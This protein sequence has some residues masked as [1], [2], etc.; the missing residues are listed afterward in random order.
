MA[1]K[2]APKGSTAAGSGKP[3][4]KKPFPGAAPP[5]TARGAVRK[6]RKAAQKKGK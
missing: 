4:G 2:P 5:F 3:A 1:G 6:G